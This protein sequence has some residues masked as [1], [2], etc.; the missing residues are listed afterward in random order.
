MGWRS[1]PHCL[2]DRAIR[3]KVSLLTRL[4]AKLT[5]KVEEELGGTAS[6]QRSNKKRRMKGGRGDG[7]RGKRSEQGKMCWRPKEDG[8]QE[9]ETRERERMGWNTVDLENVVAAAS[10]K[11]Q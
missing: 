10:G 2:R 9:R 3:L 1:A 8:G 6:R 11:V 4:K 5:R 7:E